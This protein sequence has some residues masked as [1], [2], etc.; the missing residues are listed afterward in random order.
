MRPHDPV[1][2]ED[3]IRPLRRAEYDRL[4]ELGAFE[5]EPIELLE[6]KLVFRAPQGSSHALAVERLSTC[7]TRLVT[8]PCPAADSGAVRR[9]GRERAEPD[10]I[11][12]PLA[13]AGHPSRAHLVVEVSASSLRKDRG[14]KARI[15]AR[16]NVPEYWIVD[17]ESDRLEVRTE[18]DGEGYRVL[19]VLRAG[20]ALAPIA[21][22]D[23]TVR[24]SDFLLGFPFRAR[25][26]IPGTATCPGTSVPRCPSPSPRPEARNPDLT[27]AAT[28]ARGTTQALA[29]RPRTTRPRAPSRARGACAPTRRPS[30]ARAAR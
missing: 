24:V 2:S 21:F 26:P 12:F 10:L 23:F 11:L 8:R 14:V 15:Y 3:E 16:A 18:P 4:V 5:G 9:L 30:A 22:P 27:A 20:D 25:R 7:S 28:P 29:A 13:E 1:H 6:G 17:L 19:R